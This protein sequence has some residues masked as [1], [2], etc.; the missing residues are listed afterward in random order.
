MEG[1][2]DRDRDRV[3][4]NRRWTGSELGFVRLKQRVMAGLQL[5]LDGKAL[6]GGGALPAHGSGQEGHQE[7]PGFALTKDETPAAALSAS[8]TAP[9]AAV[10]RRLVVVAR[11]FLSVL[12]ADL[13]RHVGLVK[14]PCG[15]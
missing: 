15:Q 6:A 7:S 12:D 4:A 2:I 8:N 11:S 5:Q 13:V 9:G 14:Y 10:R 1:P 3:R